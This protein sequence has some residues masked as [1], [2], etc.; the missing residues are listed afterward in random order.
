VADVVHES[1]FSN[2]GS[3]QYYEAWSVAFRLLGLWRNAALEVGGNQSLYSLPYK[4]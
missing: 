1:A 3:A 2:Q 4:T